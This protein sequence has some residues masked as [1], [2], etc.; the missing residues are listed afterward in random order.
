MMTR[1]RIAQLLEN[2][3]GFTLNSIRLALKVLLRLLLAFG[4]LLGAMQIFRLF[5]LPALQFLFNPGDSV[6]SLLRRTGIFVFAVLAYWAYVRFFEKRRAEE[7]H[8]APLATAIG[9]LSGSLLIAFAM[10]TLFAFATYQATA[11]R[12]LQPGLL[13]VAGLILIAA[14]LEELAYRCILFR[15]LENAWGTIPALWL[16]SSIF[17]LMHIANVEDRASV[18]ELFTTVLSVTLIGALWTLVFVHSR[19]LWVV[20]ANHAAWNFTII[21]A[22]LPLS[23]NEG[24]RN[25][26][27]IAS[28]YHGA[29][30]LTGGVFGPEDSI[31]TM[32]VVAV[33]L[34]GMIYWAKRKNRLLNGA[35]QPTG[36]NEVSAPFRSARSENT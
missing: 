6:T 27:P 33:T 18:Q 9:A 25:L 11:Y 7:L 4:V 2:R 20:A 24:W 22:G 17:A 29:T 36:D 16:Q 10:L 30:W 19:N 23:G 31:V 5:V 21:L 35:A 28:E 12:G 34:A 13:G 8:P 32:V 26:A 1:R 14:V 15:I 3:R